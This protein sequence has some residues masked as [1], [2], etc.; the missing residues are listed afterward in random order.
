MYVIPRCASLLPMNRPET[1]VLEGA[2]SSAP[3]GGGAGASAATKRGPPILFL[4][5]QVHWPN[6]LAQRGLG[7]RND[8]IVEADAPRTHGS[9]R[10]RRT[11]WFVISGSEDDIPHVA[12]GACAARVPDARESSLHGGTCNRPTG[13]G[14]PFRAAGAVTLAPSSQVQVER[15]D[16][17]VSGGP[18]AGASSPGGGAGG[19]PQQDK[20]SPP[21]RDR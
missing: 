4:G 9:G 18:L 17:L 19:R 7:S 15:L 1:A 3:R 6:T 8:R 2:A 20:R 16:A 10:P 11:R 12:E 5:G 13:L 21:R 14:Q